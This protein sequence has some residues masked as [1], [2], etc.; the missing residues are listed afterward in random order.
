MLSLGTLVAFVRMMVLLTEYSLEERRK[1]NSAAYYE[2]KKQA[3]RQLA[4]AKKDAK[5]DTKVT[6]QLAQYGY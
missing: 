2:K 4:Q 3:R 6:E 1:A 5:V